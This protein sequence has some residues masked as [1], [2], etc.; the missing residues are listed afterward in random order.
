VNGVEAIPIA[1]LTLAFVPVAVVLLMLWHWRLG[2]GNAL[3]ALGRMLAQLV[4]IGYLLT[5]IFAAESP[6]VVLAVLSVMLGAS[7]WIALQPLATR[8]AALYLRA[9]GAI[10]PRRDRRG[11]R[12]HAVA[13]DPGGARCRAVVRAARGDPARRD[14]LRQRD[15]RGQSR[16]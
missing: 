13:G 6:P 14:D 5:F 12:D 4:L 3:Y 7:G 1:R 9:L 8:S 15:D 16:R 10:A 11:R 2:A